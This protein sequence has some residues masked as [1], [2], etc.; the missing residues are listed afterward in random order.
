MSVYRGTGTAS[1]YVDNHYQTQT[2]RLEV[3]AASLRHACTAGLR[4]L[5]TA[6]PKAEGYSHV[7]AMELV[8]EQDA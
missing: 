4:L 2:M 1:R 5:K 8:E 3:E 6:Y 7:A